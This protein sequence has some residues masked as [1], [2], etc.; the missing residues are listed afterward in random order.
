M[1]D[2]TARDASLGPLRTPERSADKHM[3]SVSVYV[4]AD[5]LFNIFR[6]HRTETKPLRF[7]VAFGT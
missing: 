6:A 5:V 4:S 7:Y 3:Q 2:R 1:D